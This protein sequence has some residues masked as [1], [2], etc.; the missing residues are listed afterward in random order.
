M[1]RRLFLT[2]PGTASGRSRQVEAKTRIEESSAMQRCTEHGIVSDRVRSDSRVLVF[3]VLLLVSALGF[4]T[5]APASI[6]WYSSPSFL[7]A[8]THSGG[9]VLGVFDL[10]TGAALADPASKLKPTATGWVWTDV[11]ISYTSVAKGEQQY[12]YTPFAP[13]DDLMLFRTREWEEWSLYTYALGEA[14][15]KALAQGADIVWYEFSPD[16]DRVSVGVREEGENS[17][18]ILDFGGIHVE[19]AGVDRFVLTPQLEATIEIEPADVLVEGEITAVDSEAGTITV[20][21]DVGEIVI[22]VGD[23]LIFLPED[24]DEATGSFDDLVVGAMV[25]IGGTMSVDGSVTANMIYILAEEESEEPV[26]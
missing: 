7:N 11:R 23:A 16:G 3:P 21:L 14:T 12:K 13:K 26:T 2:A 8:P 22:T 10:T 15:A 24:T 9:G 20:G 19:P 4:P 17:L 25:D 6:Q 18:I 1:L 5:S